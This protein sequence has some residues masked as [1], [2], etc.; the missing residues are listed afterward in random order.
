MRN[1][2]KLNWFTFDS[3][4]CYN[5][6]LKKSFLDVSLFWTCRV[7]FSWGGFVWNFFSSWHKMFIR[8]PICPEWSVDVWSTFSWRLVSTGLSLYWNVILIV[9]S[10]LTLQ[11]HGIICLRLPKN[12]CLYFLCCL[13]FCLL[14]NYG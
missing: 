10:E 5:F 3:P 4:K 2:R 13:L 7:P 1:I 12:F 6:S 11:N 9:L 14:I 8:R